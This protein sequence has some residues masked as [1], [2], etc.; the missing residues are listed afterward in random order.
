MYV[1]E[2]TT[3]SF[4]EEMKSYQEISNEREKMDL[5]QLKCTDTD[6]FVV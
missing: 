5:R 2:M 6:H 3:F 4:Y 1:E